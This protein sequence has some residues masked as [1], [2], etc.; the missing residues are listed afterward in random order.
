MIVGRFL[1]ADAEATERLGAALALALDSR[2]G[3]VVHLEGELGAGKTTLARG[4]L[5]ALG[6][7]GPIRSPTYT[8]VEPYRLARHELLHMDLYRLETTDEFEGLGLDDHSPQQCWWLVEWPERGGAGVPAADLTIR[9]YMHDSM[10]KIELDA[11]AGVAV[12][13]TP[14]LMAWPPAFVETLT[15]SQ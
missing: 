12:L 13:L 5:R 11:V 2:A 15:S 6:A 9:L 10:R 14:I 3:L 7:A 4:W 1:L 8:L